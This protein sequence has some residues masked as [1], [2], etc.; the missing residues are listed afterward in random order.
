MCEF[1]LT[2]PHL[3]GCPNAPEPKA[4]Y[5][6]EYCGE[7]IVAEDEYVEIDREYYH[8]DCLKSEMPFKD[9]M[10]LFGCSVEIARED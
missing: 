10:A 8:A 1:C 5:T 7:G 4:I 3:P 6:C 2:Y 9:L